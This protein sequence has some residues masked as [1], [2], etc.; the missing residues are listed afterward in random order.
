LPIQVELADGRVTLT[1]VERVAARAHG[2]EIPFA[3]VKV[4]ALSHRDGDHANS[5]A[6]PT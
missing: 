2:G 1:A 5:E 6:G 4:V 3:K